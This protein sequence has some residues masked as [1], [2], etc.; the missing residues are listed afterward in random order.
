MR[1]YW[2]R[3]EDSARAL[4]GG[5]LRTGDLGALDADGR[6]HVHARRT[7]LI[8]SGG[9]NVYPAEIEAVLAEH[10]AVREVA[11]AGRDD[12][13]MG[14]RPVAWIVA[15]GAL[16]TESLRAFC[17]ARL[18]GYKVPASFERIAELP[19]NASGKLLRDRLPQSA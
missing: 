9:E 13:E 18:A 1:G 15:D 10:P 14:S 6:L 8:V 3:P 16:D 12:T 2:R 17:R 5:W 11:V 4:A 7:D 19:R